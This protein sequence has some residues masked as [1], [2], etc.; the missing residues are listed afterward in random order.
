[1]TGYT[2][3][4]VGPDLASAERQAIPLLADDLAKTT[5]ELLHKLGAGK[6]APSGPV[7]RCVEGRY[8]IDYFTERDRKGS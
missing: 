7:G 6:T 3:I 2:L 4:R 1:M 8:G 5:T